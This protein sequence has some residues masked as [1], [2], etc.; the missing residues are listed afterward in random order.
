MSGTLLRHTFPLSVFKKNSGIVD[1]PADSWRSAFDRWG[2]AQARRF[3]H[4]SP[5]PANRTE[6]ILI[7]QNAP[8]RGDK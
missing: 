2:N 4:F 8:K 5:P 3:R 6:T 1:D 7:V